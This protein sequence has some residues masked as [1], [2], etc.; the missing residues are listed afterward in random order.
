M[1]TILKALA[2]NNHN[3]TKLKLM[4][5]SMLSQESLDRYLMTM[6]DDGLVVCSE[7]G[8]H[9]W[10]TP[11][12]MV[13]LD[14]VRAVHYEQDQNVAGKISS[15][16]SKFSEINVNANNNSIINSAVIICD[17]EQ[18]I[19]FI[20]TRA[21]RSRF[22]VI[23][24][25]SGR[26]CIKKYSEIIQLVQNDL[27]PRLILLLDYRLG[28]MLGDEVACKIKEINNHIKIFL[29]SSYD[30]DQSFIDSMKSKGC[31]KGF[32]KKPFKIHEVVSTIEQEL[33]F[34]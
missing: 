14:S 32:I 8:R 30:F 20:L 17:D 26:E 5:Q 1:A 6:I 15:L 3:T 23:A 34:W 12:G 16:V 9:F 27:Y 11:K 22:K 13:L 24:T 28:D 31:I 21:L 2:D 25:S 18:D 7:E 19:Q 33:M 29:M 4:Y 10:P